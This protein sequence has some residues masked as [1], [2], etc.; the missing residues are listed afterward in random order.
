MASA[1]D[2][3]NERGTGSSRR[4]EL[5][6]V[7]VIVVR[8]DEVL[9]GLRRGAHGGGT[10]SFPGGRLDD[11][12]SAEGFALRELEEETGLRAV[13]PR[14]V[15]ESEDVLPEGLHYRTIFVRV[16]LAGGNPAVRKHEGCARWSWFRWDDAPEPLFLPVASLL[17]KGVPGVSAQSECARAPRGDGLPLATGGSVEA[18]HIA[19]AAGAPVRPVDE[20]RA[21]AGVGLEGDRYADGRGHYQ[22][23]RVSRDLTL[24]EAEA[25]E[26]LAR[27][28]GI[29]LAPGETRRNLTTRSVGLNELVGR[30]FWVGDVLCLGT[31]LCDPCQYLADLTDKQ[32]LRPLVHRGG[33]RAD[34]VRGGLIRIGDHVRPADE[35]ER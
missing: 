16:D 32:L 20:I 12:E 6:G 4:P 1:A 10:W 14:G 18:I 28:Y 2:E 15:G 29:A 13:N 19:T 35:T 24:I 7:G 27:E 34:I 5:V 31:R 30:R 25:V 21:M 26:A 17:A 3:R 8:G 11:G 33:L 23:G 22:V 9:F